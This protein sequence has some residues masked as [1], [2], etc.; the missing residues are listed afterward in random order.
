VPLIL[1]RNNHT[2]AAD[3]FLVYSGK[4]IVGTLMRVPTR[5]EQGGYIERISM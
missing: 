1:K 2:E 4:A 3:R 5:E